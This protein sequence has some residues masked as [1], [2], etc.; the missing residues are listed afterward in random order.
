MSLITIGIE[1]IKG[2]RSNTFPLDILPNKPSILVAPN[3]FG[4]SSIA[5]AFDSL[6]RNRINLDDED[7][8]ELNKNNKPRINLQYQRE[9]GSRA[10]LYANESVNTIN[11]EFDWFVINN[12]VRAKGIGQSYAGYTNV[13]ASLALDPIVLIDTVPQKVLFDYSS[14]KH[15]DDFGKNGKVLPNI[16]IVFTNYR[17]IKDLCQSTNLLDRSLGDRIQ[18]AIKSFI[19]TVNKRAG[20]AADIIDWIENNQLSR[21]NQIRY[22]NELSALLCSY[23]IGLPTV[24]ENFLAAIQI[25][26]VYRA[27]PHAFKNA[28]KYKDYENE[29]NKLRSLFGSINS[30]WKNIVPKETKK[31]LIIEFPKTNLISNGQ[32]DIICFIALLNK[33]ERKLKKQACILI[34]DEIFDYLDD[35]NLIAGQYYISQLIKK[36]QMESKRLYPLI[37][38]HLN[39]TYF[40]TFVFNKQKVYY[41]D[42]KESHSNSNIENLLKNREN[43]SIRDDVSKYLLH[44]H[45]HQI[46]KRA[47]FRSLGLKETWGES[48]NFD[49]YIENEAKKYTTDMLDFDPLAICICLRKKIERKVYNRLREPT[50]KKVFLDTHKTREKLEYVESRGIPVPETYFLLGIIYNEALHWKLNHDNISPVISKLENFT[51]KRMISRILK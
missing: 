29:R 39:P 47:Q 12:K 25:V 37:L 49:Q 34:I 10:D 35:A 17:L 31:Q 11:N 8:H 48:N 40:K 4:K 21:L 33:A 1:N 38:T 16:S 27:N 32:R 15:K 18:A 43:I 19:D 45:P 7:Y 30:S 28:C 41:L 3:G 9:D 13:S 6:Q 24:C 36:F 44:Y 20:S 23:E 46:N 50:D 26:N 5:V 2:I 14:K 51:I 22:L 42:K